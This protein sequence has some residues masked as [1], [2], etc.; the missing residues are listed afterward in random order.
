MAV[1]D[2]HVEE[3]DDDHE[4]EEHADVEH[5]NVDVPVQALQPVDDAE[6]AQEL[7]EVAHYL[8]R[9]PHIHDLRAIK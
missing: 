2:G 3:V 7:G 1:G 5:Y 6:G 8:V 4:H 9:F